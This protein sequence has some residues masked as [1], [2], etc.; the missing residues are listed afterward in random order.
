M[1]RLPHAAQRYECQ[2]KEEREEILLIYL[3]TLMTSPVGPALVF[4]SD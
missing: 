1:S 3:V 2:I 4:G